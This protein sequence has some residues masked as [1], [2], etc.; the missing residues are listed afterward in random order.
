MTNPRHWYTSCQHH[1][2]SNS[3][4]PHLQTTLFLAK[5]P[6]HCCTYLTRSLLRHSPLFHLFNPTA[7]SSSLDRALYNKALPCCTRP[8]Q[9]GC[10]TDTTTRYNNTGITTRLL[11]L[12][13]VTIKYS[14]M[15]S[16]TLKISALTLLHVQ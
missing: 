4:N 15:P 13:L 7:L 14:T 6:P 2:L 3:I 12:P 9:Q 5:L 11:Y 10:T 8:Q 1:A 16:P